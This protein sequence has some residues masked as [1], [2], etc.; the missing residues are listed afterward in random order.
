MKP[1][2]TV[3]SRQYLKMLEKHLERPRANLEP[4]LRLGH[5]A[6]TLGLE[7]LELAR[8]HEQALIILG[9]SGSKRELTQRASNFFTEANAPIVETHRPAQQSKKDLDRLNKSLGERTSELVATNLRLKQGAV[10]RKT[11]EAALKKSG[12]HNTRLLKESLQLQQ[13]LR[14]LTHHVL[15]VQENERKHISQKL[16]EEILQTLLGINVRLLALKQ[17][18]RSNNKGL[19]NEIVSTQRLVATSGKTVR[20]TARELSNR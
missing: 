19:K 18:A 9:I 6:V 17:E 16:Q 4:A 8:I 1:K 12:G 14:Q 10:R 11:V 3:L 20:Q 2:L 13:R 7:T 5:R 15:A